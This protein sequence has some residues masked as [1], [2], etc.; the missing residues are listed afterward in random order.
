MS[1]RAALSLVLATHREPSSPSAPGLLNHEAGEGLTFLDKL[2][3]FRLLKNEIFEGL[4]FLNKLNSFRLL[5]NEISERLAFL[6]K[7]NGFRLLNLEVS[8][9][10]VSLLGNI[11]NRF[12]ENKIIAT[13]IGAGKSSPISLSPFDN[14]PSHHFSQ[15]I[16]PILDETFNSLSASPSSTSAL[17]KKKF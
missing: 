1:L 2:N 9:R 7:L 10:L 11:L 5:N 8:K 3:A 15:G 14:S 16:I 13:S 6:D 4:T 12:L 17:F